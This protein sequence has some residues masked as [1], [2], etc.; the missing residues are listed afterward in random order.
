MMNLPGGPALAGPQL[1]ELFFTNPFPFL[2]ECHE[3]HGDLFTLNLGTFGVERF[4]AS[5]AWVFVCSAEHLQTVFRADE[6]LGGAANAIQFQELLPPESSVMM[7]GP[8]HLERRRVLSR[9][10]QGEKK[11]RGFTDVIH[12]LVLEEVGRF[13]A[14]EVFP[15]TTSLRRISSEVMRYLT[16]GAGASEATA[17]INARLG[18]FGSPALSHAE[19]HKLVA[20]CGGVLLGLM[21]ESRAC[22]H[23]RGTEPDSMF[24]LLMRAQEGD[25]G[26]QDREVYGELLTILIGGT[27]TTSST[28]TWVMA[29]ILANDGVRARVQEEL[30][31]VLGGRSPR[32][33][34]I[35]RLDYLDAVI[36]ESCRISPML[37]NSSARLLREPLVLGEH[38]L[39]AGTIVASCAH[40]IHTRADYYEQPLRFD[41][42][43]F[44][45]VKPDPHRWVPFGGGIR[46]CLG[47]AFA[48]YE[49]KVV[50]ASLLQQVRLEP[51][52]VRTTPELQ[53]SFF[54][55]AGGVRVRACAAHV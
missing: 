27:D 18:E 43:R 41:A 16:F 40:V 5:G 47:M 3:S 14:G 35:D 30:Q 19:K 12:R 29:W 9:L 32:A 52:D 28:M 8:E 55:P 21:R 37:F 48:L 51:V 10:V 6:V 36:K 17:D 39:P 13:S 11:I 33:E 7:D 25:G 31:R 45:G 46:R 1:F 23:A 50:I 24:S 54:A 4:G 22:P 26:M 42:W 38:R 34:D 53:G 49:M 15:L 2:R 44:M 20:D